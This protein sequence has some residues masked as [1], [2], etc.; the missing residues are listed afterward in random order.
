MKLILSSTKIIRYLPD[1]TIINPIQTQ[2]MATICYTYVWTDITIC[3]PDLGYK[4]MDTFI[5]PIYVKLRKDYRMCCM[6]KNNWTTCQEGKL[7]WLEHKIQMIE[8]LEFKILVLP[9]LPRQSST[10]EPTHREC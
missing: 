6:L 3:I 5:F 8:N 4:T 10:S 9:W 2:F 1:P 7:I